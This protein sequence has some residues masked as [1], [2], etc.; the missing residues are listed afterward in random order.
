MDEASTSV[1]N[2][3]AA[4]TRIAELESALERERANV[5]VLRLRNKVSQAL[6][7]SNSLTEAAPKLLD[8]F[9]NNVGCSVGAL[10]TVEPRWNLLRCTH[11][12]RTSGPPGQ[13]ETV[14]RQRTFVKGVGLPGRVWAS[15][16]P[17][18]IEDVSTDKNFPRGPA[19]ASEG[20]RTGFA[21]PVVS[22]EGVQGIMEFFSNGLLPQSPDL[23]SAFH[24]IGTQIGI[25]IERKRADEALDRFFTLSLDMLCVAGFD[26]IYR[27]L[28]PAWEKILGYT[29]E[30]LQSRPFM[31]FVHPE[32][33]NATLS[34]MEKLASGTYQT[35]SFENR[36]R[37]KD[38]SYRW[39]LWN[40]APFASQQLIYAAARDITDRKQT[41][42]KVRRLKEVA[43][44][45]STAKSDFL[46]RM[47][48]EIRTPMN[49]IIGMADLLWE[50]PL[51]PEQREYVRIFRRA[52]D[53]LLTLIN[54]ILDLSKIESGHIDIAHI[55]FQVTDIVEKAVEMMAAR[56]HEKGIEIAYQIAPDIHDELVGDPH[57]L[58]Q[59]LLNLLGN[60][61][62][63]TH[64]GEV[65]LRVEADPAND[66]ELHFAVSD[67]GI[68]IPQEKLAMVFESFTQADSATTNTYGG[69]GLGLT[70]S[71]QLVELM[72][73]TIQVESKVG[74]GS[75]F[76]FNVPFALPSHP[77]SRPDLPVVDLK[78]METLV[79]DDNATNRMILREMLAGW[80]AL[81]TEAANG[82]EGYRELL[83]ARNASRRFA[84]VLLDCRMPTMSGFELAAQIQA[85]P[86]L[87]GMTILML[88]SDNRAGDAS[89]SRQ[90]GVAGYLVK[91]VRRSEL[92]ENIRIA[93]EH[94]EQGDVPAEPA[95][96]EPPLPPLRI[97]IAEDS[98]DN[99]FLIRTYL[100]HSGCVLT[101]AGDG[102]EAFQKFIAEPPD[103]VLMD[104][105]MPVLD[106]FAATRKIREWEQQKQRQ[107]VPIVALTA[108]ALKEEYDKSI[109]AGC[110]AH[111]TKPIR[112]HT[113][114]TVLREQAAAK[115]GV[116]KPIEVTISARLKE[117]MP[118]YLQRRRADLKSLR[119]A[120][121]AMDYSS[122]QTIGHMMKGSGAGYGL[123]RVSELGAAIEAAA[124]AHEAGAVKS[125]TSALEEYLDAL[126]IRWE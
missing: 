92:L 66:T 89:R 103:I 29:L 14:S 47:S 82:E 25:F 60:A 15:Q 55:D 68:G 56:A 48:H 31:D 41:E 83:R 7:E 17:A 79:V 85:D 18:W 36:Y 73:G 9:C 8:A 34:E 33:Q 2:T 96:Q 40:A 26:G 75:T 4:E 104:M 1:S 54:D 35:I 101:E 37:C 120:A 113:L 24:E 13:Y 52:G 43:E 67:T 39:L 114:F 10:W 45:A 93:L 123:Q 125:A 116:A 50:S 76:S 44:Q 124:D 65:L 70:I 3:A 42:S 16:E 111:V 78:G 81:V 19:L 97:L 84:L 88:T 98:E 90:L 27:R 91:P 80:G 119:T 6:T 110:N 94:R 117:I 28:N 46:A 58:R 109:A 95:P 5:R 53:N 115:Q 38:G 30:D 69:T 105:Q 74:A 99:L 122:I 121:D 126:Q 23:T 86:D 100:K 64:Q 63:F 87:A 57:R 108:Y 20:L 32:D 102:E 22:A 59:V 61:V 107:H 106:G 49:A 77:P 72:G 118:I 112:Q 11:V 51:S 71:K 21:F 62:K 12:Y